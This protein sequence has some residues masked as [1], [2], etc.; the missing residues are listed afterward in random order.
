MVA[1]REGSSESHG[2]VKYTDGRTGSNRARTFVSLLRA[3]SMIQ[4]SPSSRPLAASTQ[5]SPSIPVF[6]SHALT[7]GAAGAAGAAATGSYRR[8]RHHPRPGFLPSPALGAP[9]VRQEQRF[10]RPRSTARFFSPCLRVH[11]PFLGF[12]H[13]TA[14]GHV[15]RA[16]AGHGN[17]TKSNSFCDAHERHK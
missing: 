17:R 16:A 15:E 14:S 3:V 11:L 9:G 10:H 13:P 2:G 8:C 5:D 4:E 6:S 12:G 1:K 7:S